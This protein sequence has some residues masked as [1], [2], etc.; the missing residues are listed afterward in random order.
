MQW[1]SEGVLLSSRLHG[2]HA[3][4]I[5]V[6]TPDHGRHSGVVRGGGSRKMAPLLQPGAQLDVIWRARLEDHL[7]AFS[8]EPVKSRTAVIM[9]DRLALTGLNALCSLLRFS[10]AERDPHPELYARSLV[11]FDMLGQ[12]PHWPLAY[13]RWE[14]AV[15][16]A[17]GFGLD[18]DRC[19]VTGST[20]ELIYVSPKSGCA[21]SRQGAGDWA[22]RL[23][24][25]PACL[26]G[27]IGEDAMDS[28]PDALA[29]TGYFLQN[30]VAPALGRRRLP[31]ARDRLV[32]AFCRG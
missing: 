8:V 29:T 11:V 25:L 9:A 27:M 31:A 23:L 22:D 16:D 6:F 24:P 20:Q 30:R 17:L 5:D 3:A 13:I 4:I 2:E 18:L 28:L 10:L 15:L 32:A 12:T 21:V 26:R 14:L 19:V 1:R 7:G